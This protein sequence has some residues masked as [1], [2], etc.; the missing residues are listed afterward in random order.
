MFKFRH[1]VLL[2]TLLMAA[3]GQA[4][5]AGMCDALPNHDALKKALT[6]ARKQ[7]NGG[8]NTDMWGAI[9]DRT[10]AVCAVA[11]TGDKSDA[12]W[13][14]SRAIAIE[15]ANTANG[16]SLK[17]LALSTADL[18]AGSQ[19]GGYLYGIMASDPADT[20]ALHNGDPAKFGAVD[21]PAVGKKIGGIITFGGGLGLY[22]ARGNL[23]GALG[24]SGDTSCGDHN[25]AWRTRNELKLDYVPG[26]VSPQKN[27]QIVYDINLTGKSASGFGHPT[28]GNKE[29]EVAKKL[30]NT[31]QVAH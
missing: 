20:K 11:F 29:D 19:P 14:G 28:C 16:F 1:L 22:D 18:Y 15:K 26:G 23:L 12:Q 27:D 24:V 8:L 30:P 5:A 9:V 10:G 7:D 2:S 17:N 31:E 13:P 6:E 21:D 3:C 4:H 25:I